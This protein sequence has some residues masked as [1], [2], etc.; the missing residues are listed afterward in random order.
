[1]KKAS[2]KGIIPS[3]TKNAAIPVPKER[4]LVVNDENPIREIVCSMLAA[5]GYECQQASDGLKGLAILDSG[6]EFDLLLCNLMMPNMDGME[7]LECTKYKFPDIPFVMESA[8]H[9]LSVLLAAVRNGAYD[10]LQEPFEREQLL[11]VIRRALEYRRLKVENRALR[12][13]LANRG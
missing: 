2:N 11:V 10:Y 5:A 4:I 12:A 3:L 1:M 13:K 9:D 7:L 8:C 6:K